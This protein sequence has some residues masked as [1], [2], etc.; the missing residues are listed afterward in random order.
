MSHDHISVGQRVL[1]IEARAVDAL[2]DSL[3]TRFSAACDLMLNA[4]GR[5][6]VTG[7]G[8]S[9]HVGS[10]LA[11]T[12]ASTGT[13]SFFVHP[14]EASHGDLGMITPDDVVLALSN[15]GETAEVLAI[16]PVIKRKGTGL[17]GMTGRPQS[18][19]AQLSD[20]HLTVAVAEEACPHNLAPTSSTT[21]AL[22]MGDAL[23][24]ALLEAR[25]FTP[26]DFAL[27]HP[28][29]SL[30]RRLL[31]KVDDIM[32]AGEQLPVVSTDT[33]LSEA[34]L[35][36]THKGLGMTAVTH[37]DGT[38]AGIFTD[39]DLRRIFDR[40]IDIRKATIADVMVTDPITIAPGHLAAE[41][42]Q[43]METR[44]I[45]G[46]MVCDDAGKPLGAF[47]MQDLLRAGVV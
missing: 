23:A 10:K 47:N 28:G 3:D 17:V 29:G 15:S 40:D 22:A 8:K 21:A 46:L 26:E 18:A 44:K 1:D 27:S 36:M 38:L 7:M 31:L 37:D 41:A 35:E 24:I 6:I 42:L 43:V 34:L 39:G 45:N 12:L 14:G 16:L 32:H 4:K 20:V 33:S 11:A 2:K 13:P 5:V 9:G 30:G 19:L 25:G